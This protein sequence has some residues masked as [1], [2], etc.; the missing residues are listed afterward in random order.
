MLET[1]YLDH[2]ATAP[3]APGV[4]EAIQAALV[5]APGNPSSQHAPGRC[6]AAR[7]DQAAEQVAGLINA[8][9]GELIWT[10]GATEASNLALRGVA[11]FAGEGG[12][13]VSVVTEHPA[14]RDTLKAL[15]RQG[16]RVDW[17]A[18]DGDGAIDHAQLDAALAEQP[19]L[20]SIMQV[21]N[22]TGV[23]HDIPA[24]AARCAEAGV[25]LHVDAAQ[26]LGRLAIDV[27]TT[28]IALMSL[29]AHKI[30]GPKGIGAL[31]VR[32]RAPRAGLA[33][34]ILGGGQQRGLRAGTLPTHQI[35]GFGAAAAWAVEQGL[36]LQPEWAELRERLWSAI[37]GLGGLGRNGRA[38][39]TAAPFLSVSV[40]GVHGGALLAG[41][42]EG[43]PALAVSTGAACSAAKGESS[44]VVRAMGV[45][46][47][48]AAATI[49]FSLGPG[50]DAVAIDAAAARFVAEVQRLRAL[51]AAA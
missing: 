36:L 13:I 34:Q 20:V 7:I 19:D 46:P 11:E 48:E 25:P 28:P 23:V 24:I 45:A 17:L 29:S 38:E 1:L 41:L 49:R 8:A 2:A 51:A 21:N 39:T 27:A 9:P 3:L 32:R 5:E 14:T 42:T 30:G 12:H 10:S 33:P 47:R 6:A 31:Y 50:I 35:V 26:S 16:V 22:E 4:A 40:A 15:A 37:A 44:H 18:V 43:E